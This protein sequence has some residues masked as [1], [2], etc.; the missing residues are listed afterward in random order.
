MAIQTRSGQPDSRDALHGGPASSAAAAS[1]SA[2]K[3]ALRRGFV[4][5]PSGL[6]PVPNGRRP[7]AA[8]R[9]RLP[10]SA[11]RAAGDLD[12]YRRGVGE[13]RDVR[14]QLR[15]GR[16]PAPGRDP[17]ARRHEVTSASTAAANTSRPGRPARRDRATR[18]RSVPGD[19]TGR[20]DAASARSR[21]GLGASGRRRVGH[22]WPSTVT[23]K[24]RAV[25]RGRPARPGRARPTR[26]RSAIRRPGSASGRRRARCGCRPCRCRRRAAAG[27]R[28]SAADTRAAGT[29][30]T[31]SPAS[32]SIAS[33]LP[34]IALTSASPPGN[35]ASGR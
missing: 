33:T 21:S 34:R 14:V 24:E 1:H 5:R 28:R 23:A 11:G 30:P 15:P 13:R 25:G 27:R 20:L 7:H 19:R 29:G 16:P 4:N 2:S 31:A 10:A 18:S 17:P 8:A 12:P 6:D 35:P 32:N 22:G 9:R 3:C 26:H